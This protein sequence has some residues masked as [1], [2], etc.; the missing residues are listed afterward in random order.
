MDDAVA[1]ALCHRD[2][3]VDNVLVGEDGALV[4]LLD[5]DMVEVWDPVVDFFKL[6]WFVFE[7]NPTARA[8]FLDAYLDGDPLP[9]MFAERLALASLIELVNH[10]ANWRVGGQPD[11]ANEALARLRKVI[12]SASSG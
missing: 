12:L 6:E 7:P 4:A 11:I 2:L 1:P 8:P 10:A 5:F 9:R 3:Y